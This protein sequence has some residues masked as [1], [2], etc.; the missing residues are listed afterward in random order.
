MKSYRPKRTPPPKRNVAIVVNLQSPAGR[1]MLAGVDLFLSE[2]HV[3]RLK[4]I[5]DANALT[6]EAVRKFVRDGCDGLVVSEVLERTDIRALADSPLAISFVNVGEEPFADRQGKTV[7][8]WND[9]ADIGRRA[10]DHLL[11]GGNFASFGFVN[12][13]IWQGLWSE[14]RGAAFRQALAAAGHSP[15]SYPLRDDCGSPKD[16]AALRNW[17]KALPKPAA[18]LAAADWR[19]VQVFDACQAA[20]FRVPGQ[21]SLMGVD[22]NDFD[23]FG[24]VPSLSSV[25]PDYEGIGYRAA[26][27]LDALMADDRRATHARITIP[28]RALI[29]RGTTKPIPPATVLVRQGLAYIRAHACERITPSDV[30]RQLGVSRRLAELRFSQICGKTVRAAIEEERLERVRRLLLRTDHP[31]SHIAEQTGFLAVSHLS[32]L[33]KKRFGTSPLAWRVKARA[34]VA[35]AAK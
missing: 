1:G 19:A 15:A 34:A 5:Q 33:F 30:A 14:A 28:A 7:F 3:W 2:G 26:A 6:G 21:V 9:N 32:S 10:A 13:F 17:I 20:G 23:C 4:V 22:N 24:I 8:I 16:A 11:E 12:A 25:Q 29:V 18:V 31:L 35:E 27:E